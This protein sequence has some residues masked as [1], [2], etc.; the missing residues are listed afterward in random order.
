M[1]HKSVMNG[2]EGRTDEA[3]AAI[4]LAGGE[5][6][7]LR[8]LTRQVAGDDRP[9]QF[10]RLLGGETLLER[11]RR[12][13]A[14]LIPAG[15]TLFC[16]TRAHERFYGP[17][18]ADIGPG[19]LVVQPENRGTAP[20]ILYSLLRLPGARLAGPVVLLPSDHFF[21]D[22]QAFMT[23][24]QGAVDAV[25]GRPDLVVLLGIVPDHPEPGYG[26]IEP[27]EPLLGRWPLYRVRRFWEKPPLTVATDLQRR[28]G[29]WNSFVIVA[30]PAALLRLIGSAAPALLA[31][32][33]PARS[34]IGTPWEDPAVRSVYRDLASLDFS[35]EVLERLPEM[36]AVLPIH[37]VGWRDLGEP[38]RVAATQRELQ[39][40]PAPA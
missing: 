19:A 32:F 20:A 36:L 24:V 33:E 11:T 10:C 7:R 40:Q 2:V 18:L 35:K 29:L 38:K 30:R 12:R 34:R 9:K 39:W 31:A 4:I 17:A 23:R 14:R 26:W 5:G 15:R 28:G 27:A 16:V 3:P 37:G 13:A 22:D 8:A 25:R 6:K 21:S 1:C